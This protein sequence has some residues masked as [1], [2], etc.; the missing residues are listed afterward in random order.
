MIEAETKIFVS[1]PVWSRDLNIFEKFIIYRTYSVF[2]RSYF[3]SR[4]TSILPSHNVFLRFGLHFGR[5]ENL[6]LVPLQMI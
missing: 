1:K 5:P 4:L 6:G 2:Q 3:L